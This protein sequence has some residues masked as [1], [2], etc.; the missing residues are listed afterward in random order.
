MAPCPGLTVS[1]RHELRQPRDTSA[2]WPPSH[3]ARNPE[4]RL[5]DGA[6]QGK[7]GAPSNGGREGRIL[8]CPALGR[9][10]PTLGPCGAQRK[11]TTWSL[12]PA[13]VIPCY[14][15]T[16]EVGGARAT[17][18]SLLPDR[19]ALRCPLSYPEENPL[20]GGLARPSS[21][22]FGAYQRSPLPRR[23]KENR[24]WRL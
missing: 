4:R 3:S 12:E 13:R 1:L 19:F 21:Q 20:T 10:S 23:K 18:P 24:R 22:Q 15:C 14:K 2:M 7:D 17:S 9:Y 5:R 11:K 6:Q 16:A 8:A